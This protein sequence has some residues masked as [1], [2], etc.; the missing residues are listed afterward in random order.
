MN[1]IEGIVVLV[2]LAVI[3]VSCGGESDGQPYVLATNL[4]QVFEDEGVDG[5][6][7]LQQIASDDPPL[8]YNIDRSRV[9]HPPAETFRPLANLILLHTDTVASLD[10]EFTWDRKG[11]YVQDWDRTHSIRSGSEPDTNAEWLYVQTIDDAGLTPMGVWV[12]RAE[13]G[14]QNVGTR[15]GA[16]FW[17]DG[18]LVITANQQVAFMELLFSEN[19]PFD[20]Y[21]A[22]DAKSLFRTEE[23]DGWT[24]RYVLGR[25]PGQRTADKVGWLVGAVETEGGSW[26]VAMN[27][28]LHWDKTIDPG[29]RL[30]ITVAALTKAGVI[31]P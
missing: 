27:T 3:T 22:L 7:V 19:H 21:S 20:H 30:R 2:T 11:P 14:N 25:V 24:L 1:R 23:G 10:T 18:T 15:E 28:D 4:A 31:E 6:F 8:V 29:K 12:Q 5:T 9:A 26:A 17:M 13:Y 16:S